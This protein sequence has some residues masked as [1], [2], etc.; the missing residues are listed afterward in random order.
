MSLQFEM[1]HY[2]IFLSYKNLPKYCINCKIS[3]DDLELNLMS[4]VCKK[5]NLNAYGFNL[6]N[7]VF[8]GKKNK[9]ANEI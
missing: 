6:F 9:N 1:N 3:K 8:W 2:D 7:D 4:T 5:M